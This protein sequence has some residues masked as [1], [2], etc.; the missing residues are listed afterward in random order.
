[1]QTIAF[2]YRTSVKHGGM[3]LKK[4]FNKSAKPLNNIT[5]FAPQLTVKSV[6][7]SKQN[8]RKMHLS[9]HLHLEAPINA[10]KAFTDVAG[11]CLCLYEK[12]LICEIG[13]DVG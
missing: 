7:V 4:F 8:I 13:W 1:M 5:H 11:W 12:L 3:P 6:S 2:L 9:I 10:L